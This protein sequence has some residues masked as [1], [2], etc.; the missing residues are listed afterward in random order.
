MVRKVLIVDDDRTNRQKLRAML[1]TDYTILE[2]GSGKAALELLRQDP[3][4]I[5]AVLLDILMPE[6]DGCEVLRLCR[7]NVLLSQLPVIVMKAPASRRCRWEP[8]IL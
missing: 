2:A 3:E 6:M 1:Q 5:S 7:E 4:G 8:A